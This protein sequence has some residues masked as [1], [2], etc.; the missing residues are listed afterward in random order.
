MNQIKKIKRKFYF[1]FFEYFLVSFKNLDT[2]FLI[3]FK[4]TIQNH[5][6]VQVYTKYPS[7]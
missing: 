4:K 7:L 1:D 6:T 2:F 3:I 5:E